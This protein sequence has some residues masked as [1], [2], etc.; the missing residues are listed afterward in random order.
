MGEKRTSYRALQNIILCLLGEED[1]FEQ[2]IPK[3]SFGESYLGWKI[4]TKLELFQSQSHG[5]CSKEE[6]ERHE[7]QIRDKFT[8]R[9][10]QTSSISQA[11][12]FAQLSPIQNCYINRIILEG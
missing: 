5:I 3:S 6:N 7:G 8:R 9:P 12:L 10:H 4:A 11:F 1:L 2:L